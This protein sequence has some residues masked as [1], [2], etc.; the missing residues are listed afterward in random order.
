MKFL[1][2]EKKVYRGKLS[3]IGSGTIRYG[4]LKETGL[5]GLLERVTGHQPVNLDSIEIGD[6]EIRGITISSTLHTQL[7]LCLRKN[8]AVGIISSFGIVKQMVALKNPKGKIYSGS[9]P[10][11]LATNPVM[12]LWAIFPLFLGLFTCGLTLPLVPFVFYNV[13]KSIK[14]VIAELEAV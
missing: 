2:V 7:E 6:E 12:W 9:I 4:S 11:I 14:T 13:Y 5:L 10:L 8:C 1:N 3:L